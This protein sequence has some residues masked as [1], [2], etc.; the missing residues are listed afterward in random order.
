MSRKGQSITLSLSDQDK[1]QLMAIALEQGMLWGEKPNISR[2][3]EAIARRELLIGRN[4][5]WSKDRVQRLGE[6]VRALA[7]TG[8]P[9]AASIIAEVLLE[10]SEL[11][12]P[13]RTELEQFL[14]T[15][16]IP[17][18]QRLEDYIRL[19]QPFQ[20][21]Y[22]DATDR[23]FSFTIRHAQ[24]RY[25]ERRHYLDC[26][27]EETAANQEIPP[28]IHNWTLRLDR[29]PEAALSPIA[30]PWRSHL[31]SI[32]VEL[33]LRHGLAFAYEAKATDQINEWLTDLPQVRR[34]VRQITSTFWFFREI[35]PY[36]EDC[37]I[38][39]PDM[40]R[41][42]FREKLRSLWEQYQA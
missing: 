36:A 22:R 8:L 7:D 6:A 21:A 3:V 32:E 13:L 42:R 35:L 25:L 23:L 19:Q 37:V 31:D 15:P 28:L 10:R 9:E 12:N 38:V 4:N 17:W 30:G 39:G 27:C 16:P 40:V 24:I 26:W 34:V 29:I 20:L 41:D 33:H 18:R 2:L 11:P 5:D 14:I 1:A